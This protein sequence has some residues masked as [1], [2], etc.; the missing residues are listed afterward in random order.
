MLFTYITAFYV[1]LASVTTRKQQRILVYV[2]ISTAVLISIIAILKRFGLNPLS[3][4]LYPDVGGMDH[5]PNSVS[6][7]Y[8]NRNHMAGFL[9]MAIPLLITLFI[10]RQRSPETKLGLIVLVL[11][12]LTTQA[13]TLSR[14]GWIS[15]ITAILFMAA[16]LLARENGVHKRAILTIGA[17][18]LLL[19]L[20]VLAS[21]PVVERITTLTQQDP[22]DNLSGRIRCWKGTISQIKDNPYL[23]TGPNTFKETYPVYQTPGNAVLRRYAHNDYLHF[24]AETGLLFIPVL[25]FT[26]FCFFRKGFQKLKSPSRQTS[27]FTLGAM[28]GIFAILIHSFSDFNLNIPANAFV[29]TIIAAIATQNHQGKSEQRCVQ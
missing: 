14:G 16:V 3:F 12:L 17:G 23:G 7:V 29:F 4:W 27:G 20:F 21:L 10:T 1:T 9:E 22:Y 25:M 19:S 15:T 11:F 2:I 26:L 18:I 8:V 6:G 13:F 28:A 24:T 5:A